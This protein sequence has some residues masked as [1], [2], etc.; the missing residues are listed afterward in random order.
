MV[1]NGHCSHFCFPTPSFG[2]V[3][4]CPYG[5]KLQVNQR[6]CVKDD[7]VIPPDTSCGDFAFECD[8][9]LCRPNS[10]R[11]DGITDC[12]DQT[13]EANCTDTGKCDDA[14]IVVT[15]ANNIYVQ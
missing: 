13:D 6:D 2:R 7:S 9:G 4:G 10:F 14:V 8:E 1:P 11:C 15:K 3:C 5:M 12:V